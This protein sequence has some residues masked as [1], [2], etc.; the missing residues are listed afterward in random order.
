MDIDK[1]PFL[2]SLK[3]LM[4][5]GIEGTYA[6]YLNTMVPIAFKSAFVQNQRSMTGHITLLLRL[7]IRFNPNII[8][9]LVYKDF[10][11]MIHCLYDLARSVALDKLD[12][13]VVYGLWR[14]SSALTPLL[15]LM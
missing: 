12:R 2:E 13:Y 15:M 10:K 9:H 14:D 1:T 8:P 3:R 4:G 5:T 6:V 7:A 11:E